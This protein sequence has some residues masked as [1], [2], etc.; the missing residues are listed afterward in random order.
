MPIPAAPQQLRF[1]AHVELLHLF[2][3]QRTAVVD[4]IEQLLNCQ[5][6][7]IDYQQ[8]LLLQSQLLKDCFFTLSNLSREQIHLRDQLEHAHWASGFKPRANPGN[9]II[10]PAALM[11]RALHL[12]RQTRWPGQ[13]GRV[14]YAH[15]LFNVSL[16][17]CLALLNMRL[18][19]DEVS[20][21]GDRLLQVQGVLDALWRS[22]PADQPVLVRDVRW[23][24]PVAMSPTTDELAG[25]F[26][27]AAHIANSLAEHDQIEIQMACVQT[28]AG[29]LRSQL[30]HLSVQQGVPVDEHSLVL[31]TRVSNALD[32]A[33][34]MQGLVTLLRAYERAMQNGDNLQRLRLVA[35]ICQGFSPDPE[36]FVNRLDLLGPYTMIE[37]LFIT[38][39]DNGRAAYTTMGLRHL[40]LLAD[41]KVLV[42]RLAKPLSADCQH[43]RPVAGA[44]SPYGTLYGFSS[45]LLELMAFK[46]LQLDAQSRFSM[47]DIFT[48]GAADKIAWANG[49]RNLPHIKPEVVKQFEYP[50]QF[51]HDMH[52]RIEQ[53][54]QRRVD[55]GDTSASVQAGRLFILAD[56]QQAAGE[57]SHVLDLPVRYVHSSDPQLVAEHKAEAKDQADLLYCRLESEFVVSY[58]TANGW[59]G[60][61][62]D[63]LTEVLGVGSDAKLVGLPRE[64]GEVLRLMCPELVDIQ[65]RH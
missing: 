23:L 65:K 29:H 25:Y 13:K 32:I 33:L 35:A 53:A 39:D 5:K 18:W 44:Y 11:V 21:V 3:V 51:A 7:P 59:V 15:T 61:S 19:D 60:V 28:G 64:A 41:Y 58:Q 31:T 36:L 48:T 62:K 46:T 1:N 20:G 12:W 49:W 22:S 37:H 6:K 8:D 27:I 56:D 42:S 47:E 24:L 38:T 50:E 4:S 10:D 26:A 40:Q 63:I 30:R 57:L 45:N 14:R 54:L 55:E 34:L 43:S 17:R 2:L 16:L 52:A 9:D